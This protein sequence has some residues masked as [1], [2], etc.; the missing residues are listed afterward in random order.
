[1]YTNSVYDVNNVNRKTQILEK[2]PK[3]GSLENLENFAKNVY[4]KSLFTSFVNALKPFYYKAFKAMYT[5]YTKFPLI[6]QNRA[7]RE[8]REYHIN[9]LNSLNR[10]FIYI[11]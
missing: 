9:S 6:S 1:M 7:I 4:E 3:I 5:K 8:N 10:L 2:F 11:I